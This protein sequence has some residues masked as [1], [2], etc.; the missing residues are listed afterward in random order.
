MFTEYPKWALPQQE[1]I[2]A[3]VIFGVLALLAIIYAIYVA[4]R[5]KTVLPYFMVLAAMVTVPW[6]AMCNVMAHCVYPEVDQMATWVEVWGRK[7]PLYMGFCYIFYIVVPVLWLLKRMEQGISQS[8]WWKYYGIALVLVST[9]E[10]V[11]VGHFGLWQYYGD[12][13]PLKVLN[14][15]MWW[16]FVNAQSLFVETSVLYLLRKNG[17]LTEQTSFLVIPLMPM[18]TWAVHGSAGLPMYITMPT[19]TSTTAPVIASV[20]AILL[21][22]MNMWIFGRLV[23]RS[24]K[25]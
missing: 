13:Q 7:I 5:D 19:T 1:Q 3:N 15:P 23:T 22:F 20:M 10:F 8:Q 21:S 14:F 4:R 2:A 6:E 16:W 18:L 12:N 17:I 24:P 11:A 9:F 25:S